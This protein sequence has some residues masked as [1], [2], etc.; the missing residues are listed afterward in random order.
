MPGRGGY[1]SKRSVSKEIVTITQ[2]QPSGNSVDYALFP[3]TGSILFPCTISGL[4]V[5]GTAYVQPV[6]DNPGYLWHMWGIMQKR[7]GESLPVISGATTGE[8]RVFTPEEDCMLW[9]CGVIVVGAQHNAMMFRHYDVASST[10]R[11]MMIGDQLRIVLFAIPGAV[12]FGLC[13][14]FFVLI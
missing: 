13:V 8:I 2:S 14:Q 6:A 7:Q 1:R 4:R 12:T 3:S 9:G 11:R 5:G 10:K